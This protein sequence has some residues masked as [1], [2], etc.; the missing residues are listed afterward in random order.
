MEKGPPSVSFQVT[1]VCQ[2]DTAWW[3]VQGIP[4]SVHGG[5]TAAAAMAV[6][7]KGLSRMFHSTT[8]TGGVSIDL[9]STT[10]EGMH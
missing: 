9:Q 8:A 1:V 2:P 5:S 6:R 7:R 3:G 4:G 10:R